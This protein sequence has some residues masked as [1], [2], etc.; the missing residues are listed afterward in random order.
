MRRQPVA[1]STRGLRCGCLG[2]R[3]D[4]GPASASAAT[5]PPRP[6]AAPPPPAGLSTRCRLARSPCRTAA[7]ATLRCA[8]RWAEYQWFLQLLSDRPGSN[9]HGPAAAAAVAALSPAPKR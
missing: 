3:S 6:P 7:T 2:A 1:S 9:L 5:A 4:R 8:L